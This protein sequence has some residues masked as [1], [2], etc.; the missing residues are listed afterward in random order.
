MIIGGT[1]FIGPVVANRLEHQGHNVTLFHRTKSHLPRYDE[2]QGDCNSPDDLKKAIEFTCP[3]MIIHMI[4]MYQSHIESLEEALIG[5]KMK[6]LLISSVDAYKGF[7]IINKI[8]S[9]PIESIPFTE[10]SPL[11]DTRFPYR[12][13]SDVDIAYNY[14]KILVEQAALQSPV[15]DTTIVRL[16]MV[17]GKNDPNRRF[18][19]II[20]QMNH[21]EK[22]IHIHEK[23]ANLKTRKCYVEN[24]AHGIALTAQKGAVGEIYNLADNQVF[25]EL[26]WNQKIAKL[27]NWNGE[28]VVSSEGHGFD[29]VKAVNF[30]QHLVVDSTKIRNE[31]GFAEIVPLEEGLLKTIQWELSG[32]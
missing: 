2:I 24:I 11:R 1:N 26:E 10:Q 20:H 5:Q 7:E 21:G 16:G 14:D 23:E 29:L 13:R 12:G 18:K 19:D 31:L 8:T 15:L 4:A 28:F 32:I 6:L 22:T 17:Y 25:S 9:T 3:D 30:D 27:M